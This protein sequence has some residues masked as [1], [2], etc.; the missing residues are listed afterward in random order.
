[1]TELTVM[2]LVAA[3]GYALASRLRIPVIPM[4]LLLGILLGTIHPVSDSAYHTSV[5]QLGLAFLVFVSGLELNPRR[6]GSQRTAALWVGFGQFLVIGIAG[7]TFAW[8]CGFDWN[9]S[10]YIAFATSASSTLVVVRL[11]NSRAQTFEPFGRLVTGVLLIQDGL[12]ILIIIVLSRFP[13]GLRSVLSG[14][15]SGLVL[16][17]LAL[18]CQ[19]WIMPWIILRL[20]LDEE[21]IL[22]VI[23][24]ALFAFVGVA[25]FLKIPIFVGAFLAGF[26]L[27][28]FPINGIV[29]APL[30][31]IS[32]FFLAIFFTA[33]GAMVS[34]PDPILLLKGVGL[35]LLVLI[36]TPPLVTVL[37]E[38]NGL[39][40]RSAIESGLLLAQT[41]EFSLVLGL[42]GVNAGHITSQ[43]FSM[44]ALVTVITMM[45]TPFL[46]TDRV[47]RALLHL[48]PIR[49]RIA[50]K[51]DLSNHALVL[52]FGG[53]GMWVVKPL[54]SAGFE[55]IVVD[56]DPVVIGELLRRNINCILGDGSDEKVLAQAGALQARIII[57]SMRRLSE[58]ETVLRYARKIPVVVRV[59]EEEH[60]EHIRR[61]GGVPIL[62]SIAAADTFMEW[63]EK[64][65][66]PAK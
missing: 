41:S 44:I 56:D 23:L 2:L 54:K 9:A 46:A 10:L 37:S 62:N 26:A 35:V 19:R 4:L 8:L 55:V 53:G 58:A 5:L 40:S 45:L 1:M 21:A 11:L 3:C 65:I 43:E 20:K 28:Q 24:A 50:P 38:R 47:T 29:R 48:H 49:R 32:D 17:A 14:L 51:F 63:F 60:A 30:N 13:E 25:D 31:S 57:A 22:L 15:G 39:S 18:I 61:S 59:F 64:K 6:L 12:I 66:A 52:G 36:V 27:S 16:T 7:Y 33:L 34:L 42:I